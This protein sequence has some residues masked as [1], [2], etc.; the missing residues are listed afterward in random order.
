[1]KRRTL[2]GSA[3]AA[4]VVVSGAA[5]AVV[6]FGAPAD[7]PAQASGLPPE[8]A[9]VTRTT[10]RDTGTV[11]GTLGYGDVVPVS[12]S[13]QGM[14]TWLAPVGGTVYRGNPLFKVDQRPVVALYGTLP[15]YRELRTDTEGPDVEQLERN[16]KALG[17]TGFTVDEEFTS[18][19]EGVVEQW[20]E[21]LGLDETGSVKPG[22]AVVV[23]SAARIAEHAAQVGDR[24]GGQILSY[25]GTDREVTVDVEVADQRLVKKG[26]K[27]SV[28]LPGGE[29]VGGK[30]TAIGTVA[31]SASSEA[32]GD[33]SS[34]DA[35][36]EVT[37]EIADQAKLGDLDGGPVDV[38]FTSGTRKDVLAVPVAALLALAEGGYGVEVVENGKARIVAVDTGLFADGLVE[39]SGAGIDEGMTVGVA[40]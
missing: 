28:E 1:M 17:Y 5:A 4:A 29:T 27:V 6:G 18:A 21:D 35:T 24:A 22:D 12:A 32:P 38:T 7:D 15:L 36:L 10:L 31:S 14:L 2:I 34:G 25:T 30:V 9:E 16:L 26:A 33:E 40:S 23:P 39:V 3:A 19:T 11:D 37:V 8:T 13:Q 20:Q